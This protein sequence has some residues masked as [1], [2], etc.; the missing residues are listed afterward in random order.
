MIDGLALLSAA[1]PP[2][3]LALERVAVTT[4]QQQ[5]VLTNHGNNKTS[6]L[7]ALATLR[8]MPVMAAI[9]GMMADGRG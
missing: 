6:A 9:P 5:V 2:V 4:A 8:A 1:L 7:R 3:L